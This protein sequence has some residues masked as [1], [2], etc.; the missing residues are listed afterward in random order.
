MR[1]MCGVKLVDKEM[2]K[3]PKQMLDVNE[4]IDQL[5]KANNVRLHRHVLTK[6]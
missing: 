5:A 1:S 3:D 4:T 2:K 6:G